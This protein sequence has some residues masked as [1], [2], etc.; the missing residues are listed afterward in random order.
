M[1]PSIGGPLF[2]RASFILPRCWQE[3]TL[4]ILAKIRLL[5]RAVR[6]SGI[7]YNGPEQT[8]IRGPWLF[9]RPSTF[10]EIFPSYISSVPL[11]SFIFEPLCAP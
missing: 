10:S 4:N 7:N 3:S 8:K 2:S 9:A 5:P 6:R 11:L 1:V